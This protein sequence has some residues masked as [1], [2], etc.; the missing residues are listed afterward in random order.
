MYLVISF[1]STLAGSILGSIG[2]HLSVAALSSDDS[3]KAAIFLLLVAGPIFFS[4]VYARYRNNNK[5]SMYEKNTPTT[6]SN[7]RHYDN[8]TKHLTR[9]NSGRI[10]GDNERRVNGSI[11]QNANK[12]GVLPTLESIGSS[13]VEANLNMKPKDGL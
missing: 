8:F 12:S 1:A 7:L 5:R 6:M 13:L 11:V 2:P 9:Q 10:S 4:Y 3:G